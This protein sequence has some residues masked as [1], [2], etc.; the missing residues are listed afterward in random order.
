MILYLHAHV[1]VHIIQSILHYMYLFVCIYKVLGSPSVNPTVNVSIL[2]GETAVLDC[3]AN[4]NSTPIVQWKFNIV[5]ILN[6][7]KYLIS[8]GVLYIFNVGLSDIGIYTCT[9]IN[10]IGQ[11]TGNISLIVQGQFKLQMFH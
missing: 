2:S 3:N 4:G 6:G 1:N 5:E 9:A 11:V 7:S 8:E 10:E